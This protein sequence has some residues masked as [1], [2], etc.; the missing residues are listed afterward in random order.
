VLLKGH[1]GLTRRGNLFRDD[2]DRTG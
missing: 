2:D 1:G